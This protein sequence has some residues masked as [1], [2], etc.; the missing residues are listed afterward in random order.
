MN[1]LV[2]CYNRV[3][4]RL[5]PGVIAHELMHMWDYCRANFDFKNLDHVACSEVC[6]QFLTLQ[7]QNFFLNS[8][9]VFF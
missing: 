3:S 7:I 2:I 4:K 5:M 6:K 8:L 1:Q 9:H